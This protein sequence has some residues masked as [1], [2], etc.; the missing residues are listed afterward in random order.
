MIVIAAR[1]EL[2]PDHADAYVAALTKGIEPSRKEKGCH[3]YAIA[4]DVQHDNVV[5]ITE[6]WETEQDLYEHLGLDHIKE[7]LASTADLEVRDMDVRKYEVSS[8]GTLEVPK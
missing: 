7:L 5:W 8:V 6:Q 2:N 4:R 3:L 1:I